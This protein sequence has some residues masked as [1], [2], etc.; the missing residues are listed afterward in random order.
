M[1]R[2]Q[3]KV[4]DLV[5]MRPYR[6]L[7]D[8]ASEPAQTLA[9][10]HFT[11]VTSELLAKYLDLL[12]D[13]RP[14]NSVGA[15][16]ALAGYRGVGKSHFLAALGAIAAHPE[17]RSKITD[18][19][20]AASGERLKRARYP[21][22]YVRRGTRPTLIEEI[23]DAVARAFEIDAA[24]LG[25][26]LPALI[27][28]AV[29]YSGGLPFVFIIDTAFERVSRVARD[30]GA[31]LG[32]IAVAARNSNIFVAV[33]LDDDIAEAD[34]INAAIAKNYAIDYLD[35]EHL[36]RIVDTYIFPK[37]RRSLPV[38]HDIYANLR[39]F[40]PGFRWSEQRFAALYPLH[41]MILEI[42]P[43][44]RLYVPEFALLGFAAEAG[45]KI[46]TRP[47]N[48]LITPDEVFDA[49]ETSLRKIS[50]LNQ[51]FAAYDRIN[52]D[53][54]AQISVMQ[55][56][57]AKLILKALFLLSLEGAAGGASA[58]E[59]TTALLV[60]DEFDRSK[61]ITTVEDILEKFAAAS[62]DGILRTSEADRET[63]YLLKIG[64]ADDLNRALSAAAQLILPA[65]IV[66]K[67]MRRAAREKY[68]DWT[69]EVEATA[70]LEATE[71]SAV[72]S[73]NSTVIWRGSLRRGRLRWNL[74]N[75]FSDSSSSLADSAAR[76]W[77]IVITSKPEKTVERGEKSDVPPAVV[78]WQPAPLRRDEVEA[79]LRY[80]VL[81]SDKNISEKYGEQ[82][83]IA[84]HSH[85]LAVE[86]IWTRAFL[87][88]ARIVIDN[89]DYEFS[90]AARRAENLTEILANMLEP[91]FE[92]EFPNHPYFLQTLG[93]RE[94]ATLVT[95]FFGG[96]RQNLNEAQQL[97][98]T[99]ALPLGLVAHNE[100]GYV[101]ESEE[102]LAVQ[103]LARE[104]LNLVRDN[105]DKTVS[106]KLIYERLRQS[107][108][109]LTVEAQHLILTALVAQRQIEFVT[110]KGDRINRRS[111]DLQIVWSDIEGVARPSSLVYSSERLTEWARILTNSDLLRSIETVDEQ[112][113][114][115]DALANWLTDW[116]T[117]R[118]LPRFGE[119]PDEVLNTKIWRLA[120]HTEKTF[121]SVASIVGSVVEKSITLD[122]GLHRIAGTFSDSEREFTARTGDLIVLE[123]FTSGVAAREKIWNYLALCENTT[124]EKIE[125]FRRQLDETIE[126]SRL[127]P[128]DALN[129][130]MENL[131]QS[132]R[133]RFAEYYAVKH[134]AVMKSS[135]LREKLDEITSGDAWW[136]FETL[137]RLSIFE[138][139]D[140]N[141][142]QEVRRRLSE[143]DC[144]FENRE[145]L[146]AR[147]FCACSFRLSQISEYENLPA[148]LEMIVENGRK[149][150][151][152]ILR[153]LAPLL[154]PLIARFVA[155]ST[156][157][158][159]LEDAELLTE[160]LTTDFGKTAAYLTHN[161]LVILRKV[162]ENLPA[163]AAERVKT[164]HYETAR[165]DV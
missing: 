147:P 41:P 101:V 121:G 144:S 1:K 38:L 100:N 133:G 99:F 76:D 103:P 11:D 152:K 34:G 36:Y 109:G 16:L 124:D 28:F 161:Q 21:V 67:I 122:E 54:I 89:F 40:L 117:A 19:R 125:Y 46:M 90:D 80:H 114:V 153:F 15:A 49:V 63:R 112:S 58:G 35:Q 154:A 116:K 66:P 129:R 3:E 85:S 22:A 130:E 84:A 159:F 81:L 137:S 164:S 142:A 43:F 52:R 107:P 134:D 62:P 61:G 138:S 78:F 70:A 45:K 155:E 48:S 160:N 20:V 105:P 30:D 136:E 95:D 69:E 33:A 64:G 31:L 132:F 77:E 128:S 126:R 44:V 32:E 165:H 37:N 150:Y 92:G 56:L 2:I 13:V 47:A 12:A 162:L 151:E 10:Y 115:R 86:K 29:E 27:N 140:W 55:R 111:L 74:E 106:L 139:N 163:E 157:E 68:S 113:L 79:I 18:A 149:S 148:Q 104:I 108:N 73:I 65:A 87:E 72:D 145:M 57:Q 119:L 127:E 94:V 83:R 50:D 59:I 135:H 71:R 102:R 60:Y 120:A 158:E 7:Q 75:K 4:K 156:D 24:Q 39:E 146:A 123:D 96:A 23:K 53:C 143:L 25:N 6:S 141:R 118:V 14:E 5:E 26:N 98:E 97:A 91:I 82:A 110:K 42:A 131:W 88:D 17:L 93:E 51:T 9:I 8:F